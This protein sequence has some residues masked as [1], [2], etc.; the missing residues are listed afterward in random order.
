MQ[1]TRELCFLSCQDVRQWSLRLLW[2]CGAEQ[3]QLS[4]A[5]PVCLPKI[6][7]V[8]FLTWLHRRMD[9]RTHIQVPSHSGNRDNHLPVVKIWPQI[10]AS[11]VCLGLHGQ[12][13]HLPCRCRALQKKLHV[14]EEMSSWHGDG[15]PERRVTSGVQH[16][17]ASLV[18]YWGVTSSAMLEHFIWEVNMINI[19]IW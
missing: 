3:P 14:T 9:H 12:S 19:C 13:Q 4:Q 18:A 5:Q 8:G 2:C 7:T 15:P 11:L 6:I 16:G 17:G 1:V 10:I